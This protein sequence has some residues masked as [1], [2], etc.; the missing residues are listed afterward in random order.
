MIK[1]IDFVDSEAKIVAKGI[2]LTNQA[3]E[4]FREIGEMNGELRARSI[5]AGFY[6]FSDTP[7]LA[8]SISE[9]I[10]PIAEALGLRKLVE[11]ANDL[12]KGNGPRARAY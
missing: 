5:Q 4:L 9:E 7:E 1:Q 10:L 11:A 2:R 12:I 3:I 6:E 8:T